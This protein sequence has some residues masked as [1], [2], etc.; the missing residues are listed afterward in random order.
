MEDIFPSKK[1][2]QKTKKL[3]KISALLRAH[4]VSMFPITKHFDPPIMTPNR[5]CFVLPLVKAGASTLSPKTPSPGKLEYAQSCDDVLS[6]FDEDELRSAEY[7]M[8]DDT[9][10]NVPHK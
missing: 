2:L 5:G 9:K 8:N 10:K 3:T 1:F 4:D 7:L 6:S